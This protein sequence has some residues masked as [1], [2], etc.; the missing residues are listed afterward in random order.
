VGTPLRGEGHTIEL[1]S[2]P[3]QQQSS[4]VVGW[5]AEAVEH[6]LEHRLEVVGV[7]VDLGDGDDLAK[8]CSSVRSSRIS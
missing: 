3:G 6:R 1:S 4:V 7:A 8:I 5:W 2:H